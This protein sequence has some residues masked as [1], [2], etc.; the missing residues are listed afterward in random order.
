MIDEEEARALVV[1]L[2]KSLAESGSLD[3]GDQL[4]GLSME[5]IDDDGSY[6]LRPRETVPESEVSGV[7]V[8]AEAV[9]SD[10][11]TVYCLLHVQH[12]RL[13]EMELYRGDGRTVIATFGRSD[14]KV[15][16]PG[17]ARQGRGRHD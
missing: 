10:G 2:L 17:V 14:F 16:Y 13:F 3:L 15:V 7:V 6:S 5:M 11:E 4:E 1:V 9:D 8:D 12:G